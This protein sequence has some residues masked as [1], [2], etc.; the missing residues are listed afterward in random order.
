MLPDSF[1]EVPRLWVHG[2]TRTRFDYMLGLYR[3]VCNPRGY[4]HRDGSFEV[5]EFDPRLVV[6]I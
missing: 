3:V 2:H 1:F 6:E 4:R 5:D